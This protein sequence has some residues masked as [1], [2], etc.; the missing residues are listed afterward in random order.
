MDIEVEIQKTLG[1][2]KQKPVRVKPIT[3]K[4]TKR[5]VDSVPVCKWCGADKNEKVYGG[6][7]TTCVTERYKFDT[8]FKERYGHEI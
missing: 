3:I 7:H 6:Y 8:K 1:I 5:P 2:Y 4:K